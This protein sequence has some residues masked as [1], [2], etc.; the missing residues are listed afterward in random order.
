MSET[1]PLAS[2]FVAERSGGMCRLAITI[3]NGPDHVKSLVGE[4]IKCV[5][6]SEICIAILAS[7]L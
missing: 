4:G 3:C 5:E 1:S 7:K 6:I 2:V